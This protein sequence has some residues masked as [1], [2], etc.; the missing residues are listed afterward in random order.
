MPTRAIQAVLVHRPKRTPRIP[1]AAV[2]RA[3]RLVPLLLRLQEALA[4]P[5]AERLES[6]ALA[7][8]LDAVTEIHGAGA[9][10][11]E[12]LAT[13]QYGVEIDEDEPSNSQAPS[14][15]VVAF[16]A[17]AIARASRAGS[18]EVALDAAA[19]AGALGDPAGAPLPRTA[20]L[21]L[22]PV[23][24]RAAQPPGTGW[25]LGLHGPAGAS[26]GRFAHAL[27]PAL[28]DALAEIAS[29]EKQAG[30]GE[31][32]DVA[33]APAAALADLCA[34]PAVRTRALA[35]TR[36]TSGGDDLTL[37]DLAVVADPAQP[38]G[39]ALRDRDRP[40]TDVVP[41]PLWRVRSSTAPAG[42]ARL[43]VGWTLLRQHAPWA[44]TAG[45]LG[46]LEALPRVTLE[47][48]VI[49]PASW[50]VPDDLRQH[51]TARG[52]RAALQR[53]RRAARLPRHVQIGEGD[54]LAPVD[55]D[56][57]SA[58]RELAAVDRVHEIWPP[59][60]ATIDRDGRRL[61]LVVPVVQT[62][63][64]E[65][66]ANHLPPQ[67]LARVAPPREAPPLDGWRTFKLFGPPELQDGL[68]VELVGGVVEEGLAAGELGAWFFLRYEDGPGRRPHLRLRVRGG[69]QGAS[70]ERR[71]RDALG[72]ARAAGALTSL[73]T[74]DY[75]PE[76]GRFQRRRAGR[77]ARRLPGRQPGGAGF[78][79]DGEADPV[80][81]RVRL[82]D[83]IAAGFGLD[84]A[85]R[86]EL[87]RERR[88]IED[89]EEK[90]R[91]ADA[92]FRQVARAL[93]AGLGGDQDSDADPI[94]AM[95][96]RIAGAAR[97]FDE[98]RRGT[99]LR[100]VLHLSSVRLAGADPEGERLGY[101]FWHRAREGLR[102][103]PVRR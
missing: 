32:L 73:E 44:F 66:K 21:F 29:A 26:L 68:L 101:T 18:A 22:V 82:F 52:G 57:A 93:R 7:E 69:D 42:A 78:A 80:V 50:R 74:G 39:L 98:G 8:A 3:A 51:R 46:G 17:D 54:E 6:A 79:G 64:A 27:G 49:A 38:D 56:A 90:R 83:A 76:R 12:G 84:G 13:G 36:W 96:E 67:T 35:I 9:F 100:A 33:F 14:A 31:R 61:E 94:A 2:E 92:A 41:S 40:E 43:A 25:L 58:P 103:A 59:L 5:A 99:L 85:A 37:S 86:E 60:A 88:G 63:P 48:F 16:L 77:A 20:E 15:N 95:R 11:L 10:D 45:P 91:A 4:P 1:R 62:A 65:R 75:F 102:R 87:A 30:D 53:W 89:D 24:A 71:L 70:F 28:D 81:T 47:G 72:E 55:L 19:L 34:Q 23:P 97:T